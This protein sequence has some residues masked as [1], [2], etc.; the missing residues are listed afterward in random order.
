[1]SLLSPAHVSRTTIAELRD[2]AD[3]TSSPNGACATVGMHTRVL[4]L[5]VVEP[6]GL[7][8][9]A[10]QDGALRGSYLGVDG[11][12]TDLLLLCEKCE[13]G[14]KLVKGDSARPFLL[15]LAECE[16]DIRVG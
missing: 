12:D 15:D 2:V 14:H 5:I 1:M 11:V 9:G 10:R 3:S 13:T 4:V 16:V 8:L 6:D 7:S